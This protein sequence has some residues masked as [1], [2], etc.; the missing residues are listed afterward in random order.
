[1]IMH[2]VLVALLDRERWRGVLI[3]GPSGSGKSDLAFRLMHEGF[4]LVADDQVVVWSSGG[5]AWGRAPESIAGLVEARG[6]GILPTS[7]RDLSGIDLVVDV[8]P[9]AKIER[10]PDPS[11][12]EV[13]GIA[14]PLVRQRALD[15]SAAAKIRR[16]L[17]ALG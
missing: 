9:A 1:M 17:M 11:A 3:V 15:G 13:A 7:V 6:Y 4:Q 8:D 2:G 10:M 14:L 16:W 12:L 5:R